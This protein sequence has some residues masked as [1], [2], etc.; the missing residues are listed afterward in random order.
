MVHD[1]VFQG[2]D[3]TRQSLQISKLVRVAA[4]STLKDIL[5]AHT[6]NSDWWKNVYET[7]ILWFERHGELDR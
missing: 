4:N 7:N 6:R 3:T 1:P 5:T 2:Q